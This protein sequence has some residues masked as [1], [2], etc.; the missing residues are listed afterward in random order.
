M[1]GFKDSRFRMF[2]PAACLLAL[3][4]LAGGCEDP[5]RALPSAMAPAR[6]VSEMRGGSPGSNA[7][8][9]DD[10][11]AYAMD[12]GENT[13]RRIMRTARFSVKV[14]DF[15]AARDALSAFVEERKGYVARNEQKRES[16]N[17]TSGT[18]VLMI[19]TERYGEALSFIDK[20]GK[21]YE[22]SE[23]AEDL[24]RQVADLDARLKAARTLETRVLRLLEEKT[25]GLA[26]IIEAEREL[27]RIRMEIEEMEG[28][29]RG[30][31]RKVDYATFTVH[32]FVSSSRDMEARTWWGPL[33]QDLRDLGFVIA[34]SLGAL[35]TVLVALFPWG[36]LLWGVLRWRKRRRTRKPRDSKPDPDGA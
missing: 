21:V 3:W 8:S 9:I 11:A 22:R 29:R 10:T 16:E 26:D 28:R 20:L 23:Q 4:A 31:A 7:D 15:H 2:L 1:V 24:T 12:P 13:E 34:G 19:P 36:L 33:W 25:G 14:E 18:L 27:A 35:L 30:L 6:D 32:L 17:S 5:E